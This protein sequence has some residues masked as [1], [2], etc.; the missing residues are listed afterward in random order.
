MCRDLG[1]TMFIWLSTSTFVA[2]LQFIITTIAF[3]SP[4]TRGLSM[5]TT[6]SSSPTTAGKSRSIEIVRMMTS[7]Q[8]LPRL[9]GVGLTPRRALPAPRVKTTTLAVQN[10]SVHASQPHQQQLMTPYQRMA[11]YPMN[12]ALLTRLASRSA[13][14]FIVCQAHTI[15]TLQPHKIM[16]LQVRKI[17]TLQASKIQNAM[18]SFCA[19]AVSRCGGASW[20]NLSADKF[21]AFPRP[22]RHA[23]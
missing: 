22:Q 7:K 4:L 12:L 19:L 2:A 10:S 8:K 6:R 17:M 15:M 11:T 21:R 1:T 3:S 13:C 20:A 5:F 18:T 23:T 14:H 16:T 9:A